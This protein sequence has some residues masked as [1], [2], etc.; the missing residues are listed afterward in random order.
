MEP[1]IVYSSRARWCPA[2]SLLGQ[3]FQWWIKDQ[4][5]A[6]AWYLIT[7][8]SMIV[9][10]MMLQFLIW[11]VWQH[12]VSSDSVAT[13]WYWGLQLGIGSFVF[14]GGF[15]G[16]CPGVRIGLN[17]SRLSVRQ[18]RKSVEV[19]LDGLLECRIISASRYYRDWKYRVESYMTYIP[20]DVLLIRG[21]QSVIAVG[22]H[23][24]IHAALWEAITS[25]DIPEEVAAHAV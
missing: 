14:I 4:R 15:V 2:R 19:E 25:M 9:L 3:V 6:E 10:G 23:P 24:K 7:I 11:G 1:P 18:G 13:V 20:D 8:S 21:Q 16:V 22:I 17:Q 5:Q 12:Q